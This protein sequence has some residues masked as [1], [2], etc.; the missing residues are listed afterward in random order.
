MKTKS[1]LSQIDPS[2]CEKNNELDHP[3]SSCSA[4]WRDDGE[5]FSQ[6]KD[7]TYSMDRSM[8]A[9]PYRYTFRRLM[10]TGEFSVYPPTTK[11]NH[12]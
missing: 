11:L 3:A 2:I 10:D 9:E 12:E 8:M 7:G 4:L 5:R 1:N 6:N